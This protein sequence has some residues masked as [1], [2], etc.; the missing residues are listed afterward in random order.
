[1]SYERRLPPHPD[2]TTAISVLNMCMLS[3][4]LQMVAIDI[5]LYY[6][7][8]ID[9][10]PMLIFRVLAWIP[11]VFALIFDRGYSPEGNAKSNEWWSLFGL[12]LIVLFLSTVV[13]LVHFQEWRYFTG[14]LL[15]FALSWTILF[16]SLRAVTNLVRLRKFSAILQYMDW[17]VLISVGDAI[18]IIYYGYNYTGHRISNWLFIF[19]IIWSVLQQKRNKLIT[20]S[21]F[22]ICVIAAAICSKRTNFFIAIFSILSCYFVLALYKKFKIFT[23]SILIVC[24]LGTLVYFVPF[25]LYRQSDVVE[26]ATLNAPIIASDLISIASESK[27]DISV[28]YRKNEIRNIEAYFHTDYNV[29]WTLTGL[30]FGCEIPM[31]YQCDTPTSTSGNMHHVHVAPWCYFLRNGVL[32][33]ILF[34]LFAWKVLRQTFQHFKRKDTIEA[35]IFSIYIIGRL[36]HGFTGNVMLEDIDLPLFVAFSHAYLIRRKVDVDVVQHRAPSLALSTR[37]V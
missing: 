28:E 4:L 10:A 25:I 11:I 9:E 32:G 27:T 31:L 2:A 30:G 13:G 3:L 29:L 1:M 36:I 15:R 35:Y 23:S 18:V 16:I 12:F 8:T 22:F 5:D 26:R 37:S 19:G 7:Y 17:L 20:S 14:D 6:R 33:L 21:V 34:V 24:S